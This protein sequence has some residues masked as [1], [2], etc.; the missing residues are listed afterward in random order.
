MWSL[1]KPGIEPVSPALAG[2]F[3][4]TGPPGKSFIC[5]FDQAVP[6]TE[7]SQWLS[8]TLEIKNNLRRSPGPLDAVASDGLCSLTSAL[9]SPGLP[10][11]TG[12]RQPL[13]PALHLCPAP[14][15]TCLTE[16]ALCRLSGLGSTKISAS[17]LS[18]NHPSEKRS[19]LWL[20]AG[21]AFP[22]LS[23]CVLSPALVVPDSLRPHGLYP[24]RLLCPWDSPARILEWLAISFCRRSSPPRNGTWLSWILYH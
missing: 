4:T 17:P 11:P 1:P 18:C 3:L 21:S 23:T 7:S 8:I 5:I 15:R 10:R 6:L 19:P 22:A 2:R 12:G 20:S 24:A 16:L 14:L 13:K 9:C